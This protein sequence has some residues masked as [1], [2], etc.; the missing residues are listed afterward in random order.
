MKDNEKTN[1]IRVKRAKEKEKWIYKNGLKRK[2][3]VECLK[4][5]YE[6]VWSEWR[7]K[8]RK[9]VGFKPLKVRMEMRKIRYQN[10]RI[11]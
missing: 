10:L 3:L 1:E 6:M 4:G 5:E 9:F 11:S 7:V 2:N 8:K